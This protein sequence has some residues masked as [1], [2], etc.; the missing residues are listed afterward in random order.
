[1][2]F[3]GSA[4]NISTTVGF[5]AGHQSEAMPPDWQ[6]VIALRLDPFPHRLI[7][8]CERLLQI[9][10]LD[11]RS[12]RRFGPH[13]YCGQ[14]LN[15]FGKTQMQSERATLCFVGNAANDLAG[16]R[17]FAKSGQRRTTND[18]GPVAGFVALV[19]Q[20]GDRRQRSSSEKENQCSDGCDTEHF[21]T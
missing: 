1:M 15:I 4:D 7:R 10:S 14:I 20:P 13:G 21:S 2:R 9:Q 11:H 16:S 18:V 19:H 3:G 8:I 6:D 12:R 5:D 17:R